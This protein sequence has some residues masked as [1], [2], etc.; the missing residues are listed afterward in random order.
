MNINDENV[1]NL[2]AIK[3]FPFLMALN[4][5]PTL[6]V[7]SQVWVTTKSDVF[8]GHKYFGCYTVIT[9]SDDDDTGARACLQR[10][11]FWNVNK[12][13]FRKKRALFAWRGGGTEKISL[14]VCL[15]W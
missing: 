8:D 14:A 4:I 13:S 9:L 5:L 11:L 10:K 7:C 15:R 12:L 1:S 3:S 6:K 2:S